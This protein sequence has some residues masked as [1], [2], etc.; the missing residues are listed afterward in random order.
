LIVLVGA[1]PLPNYLAVST[2]RPRRVLL[3]YSE[4]TKDPKARLEVAITQHLGVEVLPGPGGS[5]CVTEATSARAV[6]E[7]CLDLPRDAQLNYTGGTKVMAAHARMAFAAAGGQPDQASYVDE[8]AGV[9]RYDDGVEVPIRAEPLGLGVCLELHG[10]R[11][12]TEWQQEPG[13]PS[14]ADAAALAARVVD[15]PGLAVRL[16]GWSKLKPAEVRSSPLDPREVG[17]ALSVETVPENGWSTRRIRRWQAFL[18]GKWLEAWTAERLRSVDSS[19]DVH[20][21]VEGERGSTGRPLEVD[22]AALRGHRLY[23]L[24]CTTDATLP[25][26][27]SKAFEVALRARQL[28]GD[29]ARSALVCLL[30][31]GNDRGRYLDQLADDVDS[32]WEA[33]NVPRVFGLAHLRSWLNDGAAP[34]SLAS[35]LGS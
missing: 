18:G 22:V 8:T 13:L 32:L 28:G 11:Y 27:K 14:V 30:D 20:V 24:S 34:E 25:L 21:G 31:G 4:K 23:L 9:V 29:L 7:A 33:P 17:L 12:R 6:A 16:Y 5:R 2:L 3:V 10:V 26:C 1:N 15:E 35:W 19:L